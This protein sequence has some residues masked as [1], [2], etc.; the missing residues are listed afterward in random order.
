MRGN[1]LLHYP[2]FKDLKELFSIDRNCHGTFQ[3]VTLSQ[4]SQNNQRLG[5][6]NKSQNSTLQ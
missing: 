5:F 6:V 2:K 1:Y 3:S 4:M